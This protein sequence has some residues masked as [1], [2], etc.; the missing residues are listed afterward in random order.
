MRVAFF[1]NPG[2]ALG[3]LKGLEREHE[4]VLVVCSEDKKAGRGKKIS[5][6]EVKDY[7]LTKNYHIEQ[8]PKLDEGFKAYLSSLDLDAAIVAAYGKLIPASLLDVPRYGFI[9][10]HGSLLPRWRGAAPIQRAIMAGDEKSGVAIMDMVEALDA[11]PVYLMREMRLAEDETAETLSQKLIDLGNEA[12][13]EV[14]RG[15]PEGRFSPE[16]Q[17]GEGITYAKKIAKDEGLL[18]FSKSA[19]ELSNLIRGLNPYPAAKTYYKGE[20]WK[21][22]EAEAITKEGL[23]KETDYGRI[24]S[25]EGGRI[26]V[27]CKDGAL[28]ISVLQ[29][30]GGKKMSS[31]DFLKGQKL[32]LGSRLSSV[33]GE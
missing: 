7:A 10:V 5:Y 20:L 11:G 4:I 30:A 14:L 18:D 12:L 6:S 28:D 22:Y 33:K 25:L 2:F 21:V 29:R 31:E 26:R 23:T 16:A 13:L 24:L 9:N 27:A 8:P 3:I 17:P 1:G 19:G 32:E 15:L